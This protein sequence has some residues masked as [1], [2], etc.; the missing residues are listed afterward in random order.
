FG[1]C[2]F[3]VTVIKKGSLE[4]H[5]IK[6]PE[7]GKA[8]EAC[9]A[10]QGDTCTGTL[11]SSGTEVTIATSVGSC[12]FTTS[13]TSIGLLTP[14]PDTGGHATLDINSPIPRTGGNFLCGSTATWTG[15]YTVVTP[16][17]L[18]LDA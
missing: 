8:H 9:T 5:P 3:P 6:K 1:G 4:V 10:A 2:N 14:T 18:Y 12:I 15:N 13:N 16:S 11:T 17:T 7:A